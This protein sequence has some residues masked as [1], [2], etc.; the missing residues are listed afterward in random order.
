METRNFLYSSKCKIFFLLLISLGMGSCQSMKTREEATPT[1]PTATATKAPEAPPKVG[2]DSSPLPSTFPA[3]AEHQREVPSSAAVFAPKV[4]LILGP[5]SARAYAHVGVVQEL[6]KAKLP[7]THVVGLEMGA[8]VGAIFASK[9]QP[10]DVEWQMFKLKDFKS[11]GV[12][13]QGVFQNQKTEDF[14][15]PFACPAFNLTKQQNFM[16]NKGV[17]T[18]MLPYCLPYPPL[19]KPFNQNVAGL[20]EM[21]A[22]VDYLKSKGANYIVYVHIL[23]SKAG[24]ITGSLEGESNVLWSLAA[25]TLSKQWPGVDYVIS[26]PVQDFD[27]LN[28]DQRRQIMQRGIDVGQT[29]AAQIARKLGL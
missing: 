4:G 5:G 1:A 9:A 27:L 11:V 28:F 20:T 3:A 25:Q 23:N 2:L 10:F 22:A 16:M 6:A 7:I 15:L 21:K 19:L 14:K 29:A 26:V 8:L 17:V 13:L 24:V 12:L 18:Q